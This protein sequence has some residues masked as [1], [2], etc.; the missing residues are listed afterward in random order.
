MVINSQ[1][2]NCCWVLTSVPTD[3]KL[4]SRRHHWLH[5]VTRATAGYQS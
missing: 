2:A 3:G 5:H 1:A 4:R